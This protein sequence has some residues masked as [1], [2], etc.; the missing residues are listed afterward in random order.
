M[1][2]QNVICTV[3]RTIAEREQQLAA[4]LKDEVTFD[5]LPRP[6]SVCSIHACTTMPCPVEAKE[7]ALVFT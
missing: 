4:R 6:G 2:E 3:C 5:E 7:R 1:D